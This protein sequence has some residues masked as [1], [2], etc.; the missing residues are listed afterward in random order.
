M[1]EF[2]SADNCRSAGVRERRSV[3]FPKAILLAALFVFHFSFLPAQTR[4]RDVIV[5]MP[6]SVLALLTSVNRADCV[7]FREANM[8][9]KV[10][11]RLGGTTELVTLTDDYAL[12]QYTAASQVE[13]KLLPTNDSTS[14]ICLVHTVQSPVPDSHIRFYNEAWAPLAVTSLVALPQ[15]DAT[16]SALQTMLLRLSPDA[17][18]LHAELRNDNYNMGDEDATLTPATEVRNFR[19]SQG[20]FIKNDDETLY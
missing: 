8:A 2:W 5:H 11:N 6:D 13:M 10:T 12:W 20:R 4:M 7:D 1:Q 14:I 17:L 18:V 3:D 9:A 19:W 15:P 16:P